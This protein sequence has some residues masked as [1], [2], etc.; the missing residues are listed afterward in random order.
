[1][2]FQGLPLAVCDTFPHWL[3]G[4]DWGAGTVG[5][6]ERWVP[7]LSGEVVLLVAMLWLL[8]LILS[9][10]PPG[11]QGNLMIAVDN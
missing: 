6:C 1:M 8:Q 7:S 2:D 5:R 11:A 9:N 10:L 3:S 4:H